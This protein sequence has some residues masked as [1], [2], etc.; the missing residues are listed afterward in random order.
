MPPRMPRKVKRK[1]VV[2]LF[3]ATARI[4]EAVPGDLASSGRVKARYAKFSRSTKTGV[5]VGVRMDP[6]AL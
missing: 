6:P 4:I 5:R 3:M 1:R 2:I